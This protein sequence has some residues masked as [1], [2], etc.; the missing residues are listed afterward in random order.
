MIPNSSY[1]RVVF[2]VSEC[3]LIFWGIQF[4]HSG[5]GVNSISSFI[6]LTTDMSLQT[7]QKHNVRSLNSNWYIRITCIK[8][9]KIKQLYSIDLEIAGIL[10]AQY[11]LKFMS[12]RCSW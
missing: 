6:R 2:P 4:K 3:S 12:L 9:H 1:Y 10:L 7:V 5:D 8:V 11:I